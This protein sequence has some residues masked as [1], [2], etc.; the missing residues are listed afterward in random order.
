MSSDGEKKC[1]RCAYV[2]SLVDFPKDRSSIDGFDVYCR[3]C[4]RQR[5]RDKRA[6]YLATGLCSDCGTS[7]EGSRSRRFCSRC[8][9]F[10]SARNTEQSRVLRMRVMHAY[11][12]QSAACRCCGETE[13][14][15]LTL[16]HVNN[17]GRA[18]RMAKGTQG[19]L[20]E[21]QRSGFPPGFQVLCFNC[22]LAR[23]A[24]GVC[25]HEGAALHSPATAFVSAVALGGI[26]VRRCTRCRRDLP[27]SAFYPSKLGHD[28]LQS[29]CRACTRE[30]SIKRLRDARLD[31]LAH[32]SKGT[33][34]C[35]CCS[36]GE[37]KF[38]ALDHING[39]GPRQNGCSG[40]GNSFY[41]WLKKH[42][43]PPGL[44]V[45]CH[46]CNCA[47]RNDRTCP[48]LDVRG[49]ESAPILADEATVADPQTTSARR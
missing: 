16:D 27:S 32:Y 5:M 44:Q 1:L 10:Y 9:A 2:K 45:L 14:R 17:G 48:H 8:A 40:G 38:L 4:T 26:G 6:R 23:G 37:E 41:A 33:L 12:G 47:K 13:P 34:A 35:L 46:N 43:F 7:R 20:R 31:A 15:F 36:E 3:V 39:Q 19:V 18:H 25:P 42:D 30:A 24:Y 28:G 22:N 21:L 29:R 11:G 49:R